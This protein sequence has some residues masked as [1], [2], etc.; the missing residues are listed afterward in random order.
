MT[1]YR[2]LTPVEL[3]YVDRDI[4]AGRLAAIQEE[5]LSL[6]QRIDQAHEALAIEEFDG[7]SCPDLETTIEYAVGRYLAVCEAEAEAAD[8][9]RELRAKLAEVRQMAACFD[10]FGDSGRTRAFVGDI[11][12]IAQVTQ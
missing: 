3:K 1:T 5:R 6:R 12:R 9:V 8:I 11:A 7:D 4:L 10:T 2:D